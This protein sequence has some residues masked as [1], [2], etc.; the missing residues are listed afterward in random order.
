MAA[1]A[2]EPKLDD[3]PDELDAEALRVRGA[4]LP[5]RLTVPAGND[6]ER[7]DKALAGLLPDVSRSRIKQW[8]EGGAVR[9]NDRVV[10][11]RTL[12][13]AGD[14]ID[15]AP[16]P[17]PEETAFR[18]EPI[19]L[20]VVHADESIIVL[21]KP[22][23]LVVHPAAGNWSGTLLN[24][25][26]AYDPS[27][28]RLPRAG[29]V[30]R[31]DA[32]TSGLMVVAR[33]AAAQ[34]DLVRQL[35]AR[36][37]TREYWAIVHGAA[38]QEGVVEGAIARD[39]RQPLRFKV[40]SAAHAKPA[41]TRYRLVDTTEAAGRTLS[42]I[43]CRLDTGRTHQIRVH[44]ESIG[45]PLVGDPVYRRGSPSSASAAGVP[46][47]QFTRQALHACRLEIVHPATGQSMQW[48]REPPADMQELMISLGF[49]WR[50][51]AKGFR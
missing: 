8:I 32:G 40:S 33:T 25:L 21:D 16:P 48:F 45:L 46:W 50:R 22:A 1:P 11:A 13:L 28:A 34:L 14:T 36:S 39:P 4:P 3:E 27:L 42:W 26:L 6:A 38:A 24:G 47:A 49:Q 37:V 10:A 18:A 44:L 19:A 35:Q 43:V 23:G 2:R 15:L 9:L 7:L 20:D 17:A 51:G 31:L 29:I 12:V 5:H 41:R 30:H